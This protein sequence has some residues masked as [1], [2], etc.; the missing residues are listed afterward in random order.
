ML[1]EG[2]RGVRAVNGSVPIVTAIKDFFGLLGKSIRGGARLPRP[3]LST[4]P[5]GNGVARPSVTPCR[6]NYWTLTPFLRKTAC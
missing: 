4:T 5:A 2:H 6:G 1:V 3:C